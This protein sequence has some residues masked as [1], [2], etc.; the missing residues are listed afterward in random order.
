MKTV[1]TLLTTAILF[2]AASVSAQTKTITVKIPKVSSNEGMVKYALYQ[3]DNFRKVPTKS[4]E[5]KIVNGTAEITFKDVTPGE[6]AIICYHDKN[7]NGK[8][9]FSASGMPIESYGISNNPASYG[10]P[11]YRDAH[12]TVA[13]KNLNLEIKL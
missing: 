6:Y 10:P 12:F 11:Q 3:K 8:M 13:D 7:E 9:D 1:I 2:L 4:A 5:S